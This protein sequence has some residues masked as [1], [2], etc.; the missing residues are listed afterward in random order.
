MDLLSFFFSSGFLF[1]CGIFVYGV[2]WFLLGRVDGD[3]VDASLAPEFKY[4]SF[5]VIGV[6]LLFT[7]IFHIG[8]KEAITS[9]KENA[10]NTEDVEATKSEVVNQNDKKT[11]KDWLKDSR[12]YKTGLL[13]MCTR[14]TINIYQSFFVLYLTDALHFNKVNILEI[15]I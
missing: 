7:V 3:E 1:I 13:Y 12:F 2:T 14:L 11:W 9:G 10:R 4:L 5:I 6:G 8:T 15:I